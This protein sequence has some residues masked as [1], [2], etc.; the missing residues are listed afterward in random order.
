MKRATNKRWTKFMAIRSLLR[1]FLHGFPPFW[2]SPVKD[3]SGQNQPSQIRDFIDLEVAY[4]KLIK[5]KS[6]LKPTKTEDRREKG[7]GEGMD[8]SGE[9]LLSS[10][11]MES[12]LLPLVRRAARRLENL[13]EKIRP[14]QPQTS[15]RPARW[16]PGSV[17]GTPPPHKRGLAALGP[18]LA[19]CIYPTLG[20]R[21]SP[22]S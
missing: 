19:S 18:P 22:K 10:G 8:D 20:W 16:R 12:L 9:D 3:K 11:E 21:P 6:S 1:W 2:L 17:R 4:A 14:D 15:R 5:N 7:R 13:Y